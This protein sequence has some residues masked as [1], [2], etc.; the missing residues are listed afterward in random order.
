ME[1]SRFGKATEHS[2]SQPTPARLAA[3]ALA[4]AKALMNEM[5]HI[6]SQPLSVDYMDYR[7][8]LEDFYNY[9][10][11]LT[12]KDLRPYSYAMFSAAANIKSPNYLRMIIEGKRNL[13]PDMI[14]KFGKA[15][16]MAKDEAQDF[17][18]LVLYNQSSDPAQ[19]NMLLK[20]L[21]DHRVNLKIKSGEID[22]KTWEKIP[23]WITWILYSMIDQ[24]GVSFSIDSLRDLLR[25]K[26]STDEI[27]AA[28]RSLIETGEVEQNETTGMLQK[29]RSLIDSP[30]EIP[31]ALVR[32][33]QSQLMYLGMESL[34]QDSP[35]EREFGTATLSLTA[36]EFEELRFKLRQMRKATQK[37]NSVKRMTSKGERVYQ[38]N[39]Q[40]FPVTNRAK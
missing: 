33:L 29:T 9:K 4:S 1:A 27:Q 30:E 10:R 31:V 40:L 24:E 23:S 15:M 37:E 6:V 38:L 16:S 25:K 11:E 5:P 39:L 2:T 32:K 14:A 7:K 22:R 19:R 3:E 12:K 18:M 20:D 36:G 8:L 13:S 17:R 21:S 26:A 28:L 34:F 35:T